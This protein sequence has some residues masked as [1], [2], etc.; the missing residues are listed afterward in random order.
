MSILK[1][2]IEKALVQKGVFPSKEKAQRYSEYFF[3]MDCQ[4]WEDVSHI[5]GEKELSDTLR[6]YVSNRKQ[7]AKPIVSKTF[8][9]AICDFLN[10]KIFESFSS[11]D[12]PSPKI[13]FL[14]GSGKEKCDIFL[15]KCPGNHILSINAKL[16]LGDRS[17]YQHPLHPEIEHCP[18]NTFV[19]EWTRAKGLF[20]SRSSQKI[21]REVLVKNFPLAPL[22]ITLKPY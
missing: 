6:K 19:F 13:N 20:I 10:K 22:L 9:T 14:V 2:Y 16:N 3:N 11:P 18:Q 21:S 7:T 15:G 12:I 5:L 17:S 1:E 4:T 8:E